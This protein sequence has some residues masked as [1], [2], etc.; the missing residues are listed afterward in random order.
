MAVAQDIVRQALKKAGIIGE[1]QTPSAESLNDGLA[2]L[3]D[4]IA[5]WVTNRWMIFSLLDVGFLA[6]GRITPYTVGPGGNYNVQ[7][8]PDRIDG[9]Y[10]RQFTTGSQ[11]PVDTKLD[12]W[13]SREQYSLATLKKAYVSYP[14]GVFLDPNWPVGNLYV[15]PW[16]SANQQY[17]VHL[18]FKDSFPVLAA[19]TN[20]ATYP[21]QYIAAMKFCLARRMRQ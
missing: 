1:G 16:P 5:Q 3:N 18:I 10:L 11:Y 19:N 7:R 12:I 20:L 6:D 9:A 17:E 8:R 13:D 15:Y 14:A 4:M 21:G 2:D